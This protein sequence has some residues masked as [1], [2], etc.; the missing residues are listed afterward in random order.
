MSIEVDLDDLAV[1]VAERG[2]AAYLVSAGETR[3][4]VVSVA[5]SWADGAL[6]VGAGRRTA[7][8]VAT[9]PEVTLFWPA[10]ADHPD[11]SLLVD[12]T[13][14]VDEAGEAITVAPSSAILHRSRG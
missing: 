10:G 12:G 5:V 3:P 8:N 7:A 9:R 11:H 6:V 1:A 14:T 2:P 4:R 13:A